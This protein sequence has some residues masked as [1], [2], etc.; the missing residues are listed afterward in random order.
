MVACYF[1]KHTEQKDQQ[2]GS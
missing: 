1:Q 2:S